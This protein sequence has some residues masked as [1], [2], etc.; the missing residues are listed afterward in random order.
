MYTIYF[1]SENRGLNFDSF[2]KKMVE[3]CSKHRAEN[4]ALAFAFILYDFE[5]PQVS[6]ILYDN[7]YWMALNQISG[8]Y[9]TVFSLNYRRRKTNKRQRRDDTTMQMLTSI[10]IDYNLSTGTNELIEKYFGPDIEVKYPA[11]LFFQVDNDSII[12]SLLIELKE[13]EIQ[14]A[15]LEL[16]EYIK[17]AVDALKRIAPENRDNIREIFNNLELEVKN[18][19]KMRSIKRRLKKVGDIVGLVSSLKGIF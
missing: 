14:S 15:F 2:K 12:D 7:E 4:R 3:I 13:E 10:P 16:K 19:K 17:R 5:N 11:I 18:A 9:L 1:N 8:K 6:K